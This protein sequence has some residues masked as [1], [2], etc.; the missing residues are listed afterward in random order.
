MGCCASGWVKV[1]SQLFPRRLRNESVAR[2]G[3]LQGKEKERGG[4]FD[5]MWLADARK[6]SEPSLRPRALLIS[7]LTPTSSRIS[8]LRKMGRNRCACLRSFC[9]RSVKFISV[10]EGPSQFD[11]EGHVIADDV[12]VR[13]L[14]VV[15]LQSEDHVR[16]VVRSEERR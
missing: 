5:G 2:E 4:G 7:S 12:A 9:A 11:H 16:I 1:T 8:S 3:R 13:D 6:S 15:F 14:A 10:S